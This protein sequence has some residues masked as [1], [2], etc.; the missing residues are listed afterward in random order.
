MATLLVIPF[1]KAAGC[2]NDFLLIDSNFAPDAPAELRALSRMLCDRNR[3]I[4]ADGV[5]WMFPDAEYDVRA[6]LINADGSEAEVSGNGTRCV[7]AWL[8][9]QRGLERVQVR[10]AAGVKSCVLTARAGWEFEFESDMGRPKLEDALE[11]TL[12]TQSTPVSLPSAP[13]QPRQVHGTRLSMGNPQYVVF[14]TEFPES[15]AALGA[16][17]QAQAEFPHGVNVDFVRIVDRHTVEV[18]FFERGA[19]ETLSSGTG[20]CASA[21]AAISAGHCHSPVRVMGQGGTQTVRWEGE[22][23]LRGPATVIGRGEFF[24]ASAVWEPAQ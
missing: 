22:V 3:G 8:A 21:V 17:I 15:W 14:V 20:S 19:G 6:V 2:G 5:E 1:V 16:R 9:D 10:T 18:R 23:F 13:N 24:V 4:G 7:A 11:L 12:T